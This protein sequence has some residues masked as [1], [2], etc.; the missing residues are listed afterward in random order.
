MV[1]IIVIKHL[2]IFLI[3]IIC[4]QTVKLLQVLLF[5]TNYFIKHYSFIYPLLNSSKDYYISLTIQLN[6]NHFFTQIYDKTFL[7]LTIKL[8]YYFLYTI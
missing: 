1:S 2:Y 5:N 7:F 8:V 4:L 3:L 6:I